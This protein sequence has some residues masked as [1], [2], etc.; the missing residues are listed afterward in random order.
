MYRQVGVNPGEVI[1]LTNENT[2]P[3]KALRQTLDKTH[4]MLKAWK[5]ECIPR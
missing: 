4:E 5:E 2:I 1:E 3:R